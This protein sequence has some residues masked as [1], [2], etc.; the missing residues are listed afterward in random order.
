MWKCCKLG[1]LGYSG[2]RCCGKILS[3]IE[4]QSEEDEPMIE[5]GQRCHLLIPIV[6]TIN[7]LMRKSSFDS[8][9]AL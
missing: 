7:A 5:A 3:L 6:I 4:A 9:L 8:N 2:V 1:R